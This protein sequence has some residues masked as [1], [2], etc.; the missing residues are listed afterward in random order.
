MIRLEYD[1]HLY[2][3]LLIPLLL[4]AFSYMWRARRKALTGFGETAVVQQLMEGYSSRKHQIK[5]LF[6]IAVVVLLA[7]A[8]ANPQSGKTLATKKS[9]RE[10]VEVIIA[11][12]VSYSML[13]QDI[14][15]DRMERAK[16]LATQLIEQLQGE[17]IGLVFFAG[18]AYLKMPLTDDYGAAQLYINSANPYQI[19]TQGTA[20]GEALQM[21]MNAVD[22]ESE[23]DK[24]VILITDG[25]NHEDE[26]MEVAEEA[27]EQGLIVFTIGAGTEEGGFI[28]TNV[29][30]YEDFKRDEEGKPVRT[31]LNE[32]ML[33]E[34]ASVARGDYYPIQAGANSIGNAL[35]AR[36]SR[37][38]KEEFEQQAFDEYE[39]YYQYFV[40]LALLLLI[41]EFLMS[42][43]KGKWLSDRDLFS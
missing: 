23:A 35:Q 22:D 16:K 32:A 37:M 19:P 15:P 43:R 38:D 1:T 13:S 21:A 11:L 34:V 8:W 20:I 31:R 2:A 42:Y 40:G 25:E 12:D 18:N 36:I 4:L 41:A 5:L 3:L 33:R 9:T 17:R 28:P 10:S 30:G 24:V 26:A 6:I 27:A 39:S 29:N 7:I 14:A